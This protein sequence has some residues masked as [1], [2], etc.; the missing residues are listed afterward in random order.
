MT[1]GKL[2]W[3]IVSAGL[4]G[5]GL[6]LAP[7]LPTVGAAMAAAGA[8]GLT[9]L[10]LVVYRRAVTTT[11]QWIWQTPGKGHREARAASTSGD[12]CDAPGAIDPSDPPAE[13]PGAGR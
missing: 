9:A 10:L 13:E 7:G 11:D 6:L 5:M 3:L 2:A 12:P 8:L 4:L 1:R